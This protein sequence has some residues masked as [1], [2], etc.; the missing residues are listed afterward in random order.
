MPSDRDAL[1]ALANKPTPLSHILRSETAKHMCIHIYTKTAKRV[2][3]AR[4]PLPLSHP[5]HFLSLS[6]RTKRWVNF[7]FDA[8]W[9]ICFTV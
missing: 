1:K 3:E 9:Q 7:L 2:G 5:L 6:D 4:P 8:H